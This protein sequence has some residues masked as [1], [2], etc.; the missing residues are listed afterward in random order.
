MDVEL[1]FE[2][3]YRNFNE[4]NIERV[5]TAMTPD[6]K[7][8]NGLEGG[9]VYGQEG[10]RTYWARQFEVVSSK[11]I[12]TAYEVGDG[13]VTVQV[14]QIVH[15]VKGNLLADEMVCHQFYMEIGKIA[16]FE[17]V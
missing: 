11:V 16:R 14:H 8:A 9:Y 4:R 7:W 1:F 12:P 3:L 13:Y 17:I 5:I 2:E 6:V 10:V 15:D